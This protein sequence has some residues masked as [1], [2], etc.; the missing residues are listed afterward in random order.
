MPRPPVFARI[1][2]LA[3]VVAAVSAVPA[4]AQSIVYSATSSFLTPSVVDRF[5]VATTP[6][7]TNLISQAA[8]IQ[9]GSGLVL[10]P[11]NF[12]YLSSRTTSD[13]FRVNPQTGAFTTYANVGTNTPGPAGLAFLGN[14]LYVSRFV[15]VQAAANSGAVDR[16]DISSGT[17]VFAATVVTGLTQ[18]AGITVG[19]TGDLFISSVGYSSPGS[20]VVTRYRPGTNTSSTF[21]ANGSGGLAGPSAARFG[22]GGDLYVADVVGNALRRYDGVT[23]L[24]EGDFTT[25]NLSSPSD[26]VFDDAGRVWVANLGN[27]FTGIPGTITR[28]NAATGAFFDTV[29]TN[30]PYAQLAFQPVPEPTAVLGVAGLTAAAVLRRRRRA[31]V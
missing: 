15:G 1:V 12:L 20:G 25:A 31:G 5:T 26:L 8:G 18:P 22:P 24:P 6:T 11:D 14:S 28:Y 29:S 21:V 23:G 17:P 7:Q 4:R 19:P 30:G 3:V 27:E 13:I 2:L 9:Q 16:Y 10:G